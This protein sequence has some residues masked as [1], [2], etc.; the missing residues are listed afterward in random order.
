MFQRH[1]LPYGR[2]MEGLG[3][4]NIIAISSRVHFL[5]RS[6]VEI[7][8]ICNIAWPIWAYESYLQPYDCSSNVFTLL[9]LLDLLAHHQSVS[10]R[11]MAASSFPIFNWSRS[12][13]AKLGPCVR[14]CVWCKSGTKASEIMGKIWDHA[15]E[16]YQW[17]F[18]EINDE[19]IYDWY[20]CM[21]AF[22]FCICSHLFCSGNLIPVWC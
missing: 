6:L 4:K 13:G 1:P 15:I 5:C 14:V 19:N 21:Y 11:A 22:T 2:A 12:A 8:G 20:I 3:F 16:T 10:R 9:D 18:L 7:L 17:A